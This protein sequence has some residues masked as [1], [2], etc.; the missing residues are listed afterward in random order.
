MTTMTIKIKIRIDSCEQKACKSSKITAGM[1]KM[2]SAIKIN[3]FA[4]SCAQ[5]VSMRSSIP[6]EV[7]P[8]MNTE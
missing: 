4:L 2:M 1:M 5:T 6:L 3:S 7:I 8:K